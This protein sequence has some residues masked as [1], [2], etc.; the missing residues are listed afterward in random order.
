MMIAKTFDNHSQEMC[1]I[2]QLVPVEKLD[3]CYG[4]TSALLF[5]KSTSKMNGLENICREALNTGV[6]NELGF[7][8]HSAA[9]WL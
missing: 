8:L 1:D 9:Q 2:S 6:C 7:M 5:Y 4:L 3:F